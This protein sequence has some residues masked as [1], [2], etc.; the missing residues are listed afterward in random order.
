L[1]ATFKIVKNKDKVLNDNE[2]KTRI[3]TAINQFFAL[4]N[5]DF[6]EQFYFSELANYVMYQLAPDVS[7]F[8]IVPK[9]E[10]QSFG[11]LYEIKAEADEIF[12]SGADV[13]NI[14]VIDAVTASRLKAQ[15]TITTQAASVNA[16]IQSSALDD[17]SARVTSTNNVINN[18]NTGTTY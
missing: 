9:Q 2:I 16:G 5:W 18:T 8:I 3:I 11:S 10:E 13:T 7:T 12:I 15:N 4:D 6:G 14:E 1:Q 17:A